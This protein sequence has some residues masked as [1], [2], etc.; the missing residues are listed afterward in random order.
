MS[1]LF[2]QPLLASGYLPG[3]NRLRSKQLHHIIGST[4]VLMIVVHVAGLWITS[5]PDVIDALLFRSATPFSLWGV[6][7]MWAVFS[8]ASLAAIRKSARIKPHIW[9][10]AHKILAA[11]IV[12]GS[13]I[14]AILI[15]GTMES[16][17]KYALCIFLSGVTFM[18]IVKM[19]VKK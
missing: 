1:L 8:T 16:F 3:V 5:P 13:V 11:I 17:S 14:H 4:L 15:D 2:L 19:G 10:V 9:K 12:I 6:I 7:A 18:T